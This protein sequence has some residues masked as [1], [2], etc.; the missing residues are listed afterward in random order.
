MPARDLLELEPVRHRLL[1]HA[2]VARADRLGLRAPGGDL[3]GIV[4]M[5][6]EPGGDGLL[7]V[8]GKLTVHISVEFVVGDGRGVV[9][10]R[11]T[12]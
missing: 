10:H 4:G 8:G 11:S 9:K 2:L 12:F 7:P 6:G 5:R 1:R 3:L